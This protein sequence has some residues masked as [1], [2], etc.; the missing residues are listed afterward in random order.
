MF[1]TK[2]PEVVNRVAQSEILMAFRVTIK[3]A[4]LGHI[5]SFSKYDSGVELTMRL[6]N[7]I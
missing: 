2:V 7:D 6:E 3:R 4:G 1:C 5:V